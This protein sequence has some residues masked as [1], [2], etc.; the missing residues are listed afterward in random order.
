MMGPTNAKTVYSVNGK[1]GVVT[2]G[3]ADIF[4]ASTNTGTDTKPV[5]I[6]NGVATAVTN[7]LATDSAV[8]HLAGAETIPGAKTFSATPTVLATND[9]AHLDL[10]STRV[11]GNLGAVIFRNSN[12]NIINSMSSTVE[13]QLSLNLENGTTKRAVIVGQRAYDA[14]NT[15]DVVTIG[16]LQA[17]TDVVHT[18]GNETIGGDKTFTGEIRKN[19]GGF[20]TINTT[21]T[22]NILGEDQYFIFAKV[23]AP[24]STY[25]NM[26]FFAYTRNVLNTGFYRLGYSSS[27]V[28]MDITS[29][30][31]VP[32][33]FKIFKDSNNMY[34]LAS[35]LPANSIT[36]L[37]FKA[38]IDSYSR[39][40]PTTDFSP[41]AVPDSGYTEVLST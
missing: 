2:L 27:S 18:T 41:Y 40:V 8:V 5:K 20:L 21:S 24:A 16:S 14:N 35:Y 39:G 11:S 19:N 36:I 17:S 12:G 9:L 28:S 22:K 3:Q 26:Y 7:D 1:K 25:L 31:S 6:V 38:V 15:S 33:N 32:L 37:E 34:Y 13:G 10:K 29:T 4:G 23:S 30:A